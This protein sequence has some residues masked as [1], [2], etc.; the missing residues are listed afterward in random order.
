MTSVKIKKRNTINKIKT[1]Q[2]KYVP[3]YI[4]K[5]NADRIKQLRKKSKLTYNEIFS[6]WLDKK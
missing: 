1:G 2:F 6:N 4:S 5:E 3:F